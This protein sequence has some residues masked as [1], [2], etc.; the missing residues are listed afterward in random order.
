MLCP[1][2]KKEEKKKELKK[3]KQEVQFALSVACKKR[4]NTWFGSE[5]CSV[6]EGLPSEGR[7]CTL[8][9]LST[10]GRG[11]VSKYLLTA[12]MSGEV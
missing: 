3:Q 2:K 12:V 11:I 9:L 8:A 10:I 5:I 4:G 7:R 6:S 1:S